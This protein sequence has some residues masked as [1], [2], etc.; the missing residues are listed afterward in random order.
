MIYNGRSPEDD[1][2]GEAW[3]TDIRMD[4]CIEYSTNF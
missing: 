4:R 1:L 3:R 2:E